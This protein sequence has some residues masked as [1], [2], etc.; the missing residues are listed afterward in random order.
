MFP[1]TIRNYSHIFTY[2][3]KYKNII[4]HNVQLKLLIFDKVGEVAYNYNLRLRN[5]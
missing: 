5:G 3:P 4:K 2:K 1:K